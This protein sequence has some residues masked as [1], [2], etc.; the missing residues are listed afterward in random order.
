MSGRF[1]GIQEG[2]LRIK[3][4]GLLLCSGCY[5]ITATFINDFTS[6]A[7]GLESFSGCFLNSLNLRNISCFH[8]LFD[9]S[10]KCIWCLFNLLRRASASFLTIN[11]NNSIF[12][13]VLIRL[14]LLKHFIFDLQLLLQSVN[15]NFQ[16]FVFPLV[17]QD[18]I[19]QK[20]LVLFKRFTSWLPVLNSVKEL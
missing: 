2:Y 16:H 17:F 3:E 7:Y 8:C 18:L 19:L 4:T 14:E 11:N 10:N 15:W 13:L 9:S 20:V 12:L 5:H 1:E 6:N